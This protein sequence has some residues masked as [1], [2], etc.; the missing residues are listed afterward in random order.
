MRR[1]MVASIWYRIAEA[2]GMAKSIRFI[3]GLH[4]YSLQSS[5][6]LFPVHI[7]AKS[8]IRQSLK[9]SS[10]TPG[11]ICGRYRRRSDKQRIAEAFHLGMGLDELCVES[12][13]DIGSGSI[14]PVVL[15]NQMGGARDC[16]HAL[17]LQ[18]AGP[19]AVQRSVRRHRTGEILEGV[20]PTAPLH[21]SGGRDFRVAEDG[22]EEEVQVQDFYSGARTLRNGRRLEFMEEPVDQGNGSGHSR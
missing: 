12:E 13:D 2:E 11:L 1:A 7:G 8:Q 21:R 3:V 10:C 6:A 19:A 4:P 20:V 9:I 22:R 15:T 18:T 16:A 17:G 5:G 14:Q